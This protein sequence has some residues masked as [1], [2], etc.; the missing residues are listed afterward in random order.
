[1]SDGSRTDQNLPGSAD[2]YAAKVTSGLTVSGGQLVLNTAFGNDGLLAYFTPTTVDLGIGDSLQISFDFSVS[3]TLASQDRA[4]GVFLYNS[5]GNRLTTDDT[6]GFNSALFNAYTGYGVTYDPDSANPARYRTT[7]R[8]LTAN[9]LFS[10]TPNVALGS[11]AA[12]AILTAGQTYAGSLTVTRNAG[13]VSVKGN[14]NGALISNTDPSS[15][16]TAFDTVA[17]LATSS[18]IPQFTLDNIVVT[19]ISAAPEPSTFA[20]LGFG[21]LFSGGGPESPALGKKKHLMP[22]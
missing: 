11:A 9:N 7:E 5:G 3:G 4:I 14:I 12:S 17:F 10:A 2:W 16:Y 20:L 15:R 18:D 22:F 21:L 13:S 19:E 1:M 6:S 8:N